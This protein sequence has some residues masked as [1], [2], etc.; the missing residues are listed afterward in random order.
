MAN[1]L[2]MEEFL[3]PSESTEQANGELK[4]PH[5]LLLDLDAKLEKFSF[6]KFTATAITGSVSLKDNLLTLNTLL[7]V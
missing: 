3:L 6:G 4:L 7:H 5:Y 2:I 1:Q